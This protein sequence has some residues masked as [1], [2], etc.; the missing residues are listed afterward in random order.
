MALNTTRSILWSLIARFSFNTSSTCQEIASPSRS[1]SVAR[2]RRSAPLSDLAMSLSRPA[3]LGSTSH[4]IRKFCSGSTDPFLAGRSRTWPN[5]ARTSY[6]EPKYLLIVLAFA[7]D[8]TM[9]IFMSFQ[10][11]TGKIT[12]GSARFASAV[13][14]RTWVVRGFLSNRQMLKTYSTVLTDDQK[15]CKIRPAVAL[16]K[17]GYLDNTRY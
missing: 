17:R 1:G 16:S 14:K 8:S 13:W 6:E 15:S 4:I 10:W 12:A 11:L 9:T 2:I 3:A 5:E 7:G